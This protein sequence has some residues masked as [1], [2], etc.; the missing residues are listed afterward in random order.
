MCGQHRAAGQGDAG[1]VRLESLL[2]VTS[3]V[4]GASFRYD[5]RGDQ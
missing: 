5:Q 4:E 3:G 1:P 2:A